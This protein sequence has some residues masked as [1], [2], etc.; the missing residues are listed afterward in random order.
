MMNS[1]K[2]IFVAASLAGILSINI[3]NSEAK[4]SYQFI[5]QAKS[6]SLTSR[7]STSSVEVAFTPAATVVV[8]VSAITCPAWTGEG[9]QEPEPDGYTLLSYANDDTSKI[10]ELELYKLN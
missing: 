1:K 8:F 6:T 9:D 2:S 3:F 4:D 7:S 5:N 10:K